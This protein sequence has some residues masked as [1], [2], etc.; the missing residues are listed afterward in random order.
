MNRAVEITTTEG[1]VQGIE[2]V[3]DY[4]N[5]TDGVDEAIADSTP[6]DWLT[7][8]TVARTDADDT[9]VDD[10]LYIARE[11]LYQARD[12]LYRGEG[13]DVAADADLTYGEWLS[14]RADALS[15]T[16]PR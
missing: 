9:R 13:P 8:W 4:L 2:Y 10:T 12:A 11:A 3:A 16:G 5:N 15:E 7:R 6:D 1:P 14:N